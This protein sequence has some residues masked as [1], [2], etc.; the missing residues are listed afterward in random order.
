MSEIE[1][2]ESRGFQPGDVTNGHLPI[3]D[4]ESAVEA[5]LFASSDPLTKDELAE[6]IGA[7]AWMIDEALL[8]LST[9]YA[10]GGGLR[11]LKVAGG[12]RMETRPEYGRYIARLRQEPPKRL[13]RAGLETLAIVAY[14]QPVTAPEV[15]QIR[16][17]CSDSSVQHLMERGLIHA[18][19]RKKAPGRP[20]LYA[21]TQDFLTQFGLR[22]LN[23]LPPIEDLGEAALALPGAATM[24]LPL[25]GSDPP[26]EEE[27]HPPDDDGEAE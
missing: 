20:I 8:G 27:T 24:L 1:S 5:L 26:Q 11:I 14:R 23:D 2:G 9:R 3:P 19:G 16:G 7:D 10:D 17:V 18:V 15:D 12:W 22:D 13:S 25:D 21:T 4:M 6:A